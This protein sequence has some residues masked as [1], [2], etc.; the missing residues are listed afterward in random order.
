[1][2][3]PV[4]NATDGAWGVRIYVK[5]FINWIWFGCIFMALG[6]VLAIA[7]KRYRLKP[8][9]IAEA[10]V[11]APAAGSSAAGTRAKGS[12]GRKNSPQGAD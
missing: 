6:G 3:E 2:G 11:A 4:E 9:R 12:R 8:R 7:D 1:M 10:P 5:P